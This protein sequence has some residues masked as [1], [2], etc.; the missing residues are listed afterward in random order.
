MYIYVV[1]S[2]HMKKLRVLDEVLKSTV[3]YGNMNLLV[4]KGVILKKVTVLAGFKTTTPIKSIDRIMRDYPRYK[5]E[6]QKKTGTANGKY[7][8]YE[9]HYYGNGEEQFYHK[10]VRIFK[11]EEIS[12]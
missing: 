6:W 7:F 3:E 10:I 9:I 1:N 2:L 4:P 5:S 11:R 12:I 8:D